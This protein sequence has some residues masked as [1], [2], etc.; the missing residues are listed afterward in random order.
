MVLQP[1]T[2]YAREPLDRLVE[3]VPG[4]VGVPVRLGPTVK[5][6]FNNLLAIQRY[7]YLAPFCRYLRM[8]P[9]ARR[10]QC[11][12]AGHVELINRSAAVFVQDR[13]EAAM[14]FH[15]YVEQDVQ[16]PLAGPYGGSR[17]R[18]FRYAGALQRPILAATNR[19]AKETPTLGVARG[20]LSSIHPAI[21]F[22]HLHKLPECNTL[23]NN[24]LVP[25]TPL[26]Q[27]D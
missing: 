6:C 8:V 2:A 26:H 13:H 7:G 17:A 19:L 16:S 5:L 15:L 3:S 12:L 27:G 10:L 18:P 11:Q 24:S 23:R 25:T 14:E 4:P 20:R 9:F 21:P 1:D 22:G